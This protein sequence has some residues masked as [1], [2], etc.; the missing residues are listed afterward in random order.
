VG[1]GEKEPSGKKK[2]LP[3]RRYDTGRGVTRRCFYKEYR[4]GKRTG[5]DLKKLRKTVN[6][7]W[8]GK[9]GVGFNGKNRTFRRGGAMKR[10][11]KAVGIQ[12]KRNHRS[13]L[14]REM[15]VIWGGREASG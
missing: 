5:K 12:T 14:Q 7:I 1:T 9:G 2:N 13:I 4:P 15:S 6:R 11:I 3:I 10:L 8:K